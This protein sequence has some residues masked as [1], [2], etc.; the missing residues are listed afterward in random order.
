MTASS[1]ARCDST[2]IT[3]PPPRAE[4]QKLTRQ[5]LLH[6]GT[7]LVLTHG[8]TATSIDRIA[9]HAGCTRGTFFAHFGHKQQIGHE[10]ADTLARHAIQ[11][12]RRFQPC[13]GDH[14]LA[15]LARWASILVRRPGWIRLE[16]DL[17][18]LDPSSRAQANQRL[19][20]L[21]DTVRDMLATATAPPDSRVDLDV[22]ISFLL[23][24][25]VGMATQHTHNPGMPQTAIRPHIALILRTAG[26]G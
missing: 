2:D 3:A 13:D 11:R 15:T 14:I 22:T 4:R 1:P 18:D 20:H 24:V 26:I 10:V 21:R 19:H 17:A 7:E 5:R 25:L 16:L 12:V 23:S 8:Y 6:A 9:E